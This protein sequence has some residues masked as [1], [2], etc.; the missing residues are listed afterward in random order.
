MVAAI[1]SKKPCLCPPVALLQRS[2]RTCS[3]APLPAGTG[4]PA[5]VSPR[6]NF[7]FPV[8]CC[9][10]RT[11]AIPHTCYLQI[12]CWHHQ[13]PSSPVAWSQ[14]DSRQTRKLPSKP[15][16]KVSL[17][18]ASQV[19]LAGHHWD[20]GHKI[21]W[22]APYWGNRPQ[23][24][25]IISQLTYLICIFNRGIINCSAFGFSSHAR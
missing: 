10:Y 19:S 23:L 20:D 13:L 22:V 1:P 8:K 17:T 24:I 14:R 18:P 9:D 16:A 2:L 6:Q 4:L 12:K 7:G 25:G 15:S 21:T 3:L 11:Q 5:E